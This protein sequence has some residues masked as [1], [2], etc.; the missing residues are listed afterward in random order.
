V[1]ATSPL[2]AVPSD[3]ARQVRNNVAKVR[4]GAIGD[5]HYNVASA[6]SLQAYFQDIR[7]YADV[8][9]LC[10][11]LTD[12]GLPE[13][14]K[15]LA[16]DLSA[17]RLPMVAVLGNHDYESG[18]AA[19]VT[20][21]LHGAGVEVLDGEAVMIGEI[22]FAGVKGFGG[23]FD[24][25]MLQPWGEPGVK[26]FVR[27]AVD[28]ALKLDSALAKIRSP[29]RIVLMHYG[30][31]RGTSEGEP[32]E[33]FPFLGSSRLEEPCNRYAASVV[34]HGHVHRGTHEA[35]TS[36]G[37][38]VYNVALP[39]LRRL[40]PEGPALKVFAIDVARDHQTAG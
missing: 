13:E 7:R 28:E 34:V 12:H 16:A 10:G 17:V 23:G 35:T 29:N 6:G 27:A 4:V 38:P 30:P 25:H 14:A 5:T 20:N 39:L 26:D 2:A 24:R 3:N 36:A 1:R 31:V 33:I 19:E 40:H 32:P 21:I 18:H 11:D 22:G 15:A 9:L 8:L 37:I